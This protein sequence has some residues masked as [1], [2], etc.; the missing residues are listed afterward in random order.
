MSSLCVLETAALSV[1]AV[2][3]SSDELPGKKQLPGQ[4][5]A[6]THPAYATCLQSCQLLTHTCYGNLKTDSAASVLHPSVCLRV[7][8][9]SLC[10]IKG[11]PLLDTESQCCRVFLCF[12]R[13]TAVWLPRC[14]A[15][16]MAAGRQKQEQNR[17]GSSYR[18][19]L[20]PLHLSVSLSVLGA[21]SLQPRSSRELIYAAL[22]RDRGKSWAP[23]IFRSAGHSEL[24]LY[25]RQRQLQGF[26]ETWPLP[27]A[28]VQPPFHLTFPPLSLLLASSSTALAS[29][30]SQKLPTCERSSCCHRARRGINDSSLGCCEQQ[31]VSSCGTIDFP[32]C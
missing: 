14:Q 28:R 13:Q 4:G 10:L 20:L 9:G 30:I 22:E 2:W 25:V 19:D 32:P 27:R 16:G 24:N 11:T 29:I 12:N 6:Q 17:T 21:L 15:L 26:R 8:P 23:A 18:T 1:T 5:T 31:C 7:T 3:N